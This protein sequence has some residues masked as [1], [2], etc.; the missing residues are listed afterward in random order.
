MNKTRRAKLNAVI[1]AL[2]ALK[3]DVELLQEE[4]QE[5]FDNLPESIQETDRGEAIQDAADSMSDAADLIDEAMEALEIA[6][7]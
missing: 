7:E 6:M 1:N 5:A 4:E 3:S 2:A